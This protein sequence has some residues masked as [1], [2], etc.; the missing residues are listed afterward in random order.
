MSKEKCTVCNRDPNRCNSA[1]AECSHVECPSRRKAWSDGL[2]GVHPPAPFHAPRKRLTDGPVPVDV[3][4][5][6]AR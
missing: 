5:G 3:V 6:P 4:L 2:Q 1:V